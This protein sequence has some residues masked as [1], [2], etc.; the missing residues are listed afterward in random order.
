MTARLRF[1]P[2]PAPIARCSLCGGSARRGILATPANDRI[3]GDALI[4]ADCADGISS[5]A[6][7]ARQTKQTK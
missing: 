2:H 3:E 6:A 5:A 4:C 7:S 1:A